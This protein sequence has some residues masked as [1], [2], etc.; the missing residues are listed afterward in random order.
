MVSNVSSSRR[1][2]NEYPQVHQDTKDHCLLKS[3]TGMPF[4]PASLPDPKMPQYSPNSEEW[5]SQ[6]VLMKLGAR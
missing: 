1:R 5:Q 6:A 3:K 2:V 4:F